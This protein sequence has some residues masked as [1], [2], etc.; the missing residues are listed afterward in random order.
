VT[1]SIGPASEV[2]VAS[3]ISP[4]L[5]V[6]PGT[7]LEEKV[8]F[9]LPRADEAQERLNDLDHR[10][11]GEVEARE[12]AVV[13]AQNETE[14]RLREAITNALDRHKR[15]RLIGIGLLTLGAILLNLGNFA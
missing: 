8:G 2:S 12:R 10:M 13:A 14:R 15:L 3:R 6:S 9:L 5:S 11:T 1:I 7:R 4:K